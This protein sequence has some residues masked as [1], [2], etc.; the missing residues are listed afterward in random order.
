MDIVGMLLKCRSEELL[1]EVV[2]VM[3]EEDMV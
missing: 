1:M 3:M 2:L